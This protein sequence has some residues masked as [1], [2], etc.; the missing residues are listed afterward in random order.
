MG[1]NDGCR[2]PSDPEACAHGGAEP[3]PDQPQVIRWSLPLNPALPPKQRVCMA[4]PA[5]KPLQRKGLS[6]RGGFFKYW[7][8]GGA[9]ANT[10][11][12]E[13]WQPACILSPPCYSIT[14][15]ALVRRTRITTAACERQQLRELV[16]H[17]R[18]HVDA[19]ASRCAAG[20]T[21]TTR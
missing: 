12:W 21:S 14:G 4:F 18:E 10:E 5:E 17:A 2:H 9:A 13:R 8:R 19:Y 6:T 1:V 16:K 15:E 20:M 7:E 11:Q 3:L